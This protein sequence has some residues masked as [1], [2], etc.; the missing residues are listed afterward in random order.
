VY[1]LVDLVF[2]CW[3]LKR[4]VV[5]DAGRSA[6]LTRTAEGDERWDTAVPRHLTAPK[7][8][9]ARLPQVAAGPAPPA[10]TLQSSPN[11]GQ[12]V[13]THLALRSRCAP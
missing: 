9:L 11:Q 4:W 1:G 13:S 3:T 10:A 5:H 2:C 12:R 6:T 8:P 7:N